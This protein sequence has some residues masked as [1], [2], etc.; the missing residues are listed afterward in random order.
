MP[1]METSQTWLTVQSQG[2]AL[3]SEHNDI[4]PH[5]IGQ[6][7]SLKAAVVCVHD[8][9]RHLHR[10]ECEFVFSGH[11]KHVHMDTRILMSGEADVADLAC[12]PGLDEDCLGALR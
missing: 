6:D 2:Q 11:F 8:V 1:T 4:L 5:E 9:E 10:I 12:L 7:H 3:H